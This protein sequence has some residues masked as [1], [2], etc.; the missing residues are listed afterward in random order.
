M[1]EKE[2]FLKKGS[3]A[4]LLSW[5][6]L[7][8]GKTSSEGEGPK[9]ENSPNIPCLFALKMNNNTKRNKQVILNR[10]G[11]FLHNSQNFRKRN[12]GQNMQPQIQECRFIEHLLKSRNLHSIS[13]LPSSVL[14]LTH[15]LNQFQH[16]RRIAQFNIAHMM[17]IWCPYAKFP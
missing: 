4:L 8:P 7:S 5:L 15:K 6:K 17:P 1:I 12:F 2:Y 13:Q 14:Y 3:K 10:S 16:T 11:F 9:Y